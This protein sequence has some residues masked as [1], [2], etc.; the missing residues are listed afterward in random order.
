[1][2]RRDHAAVLPKRAVD[3]GVGCVAGAAR[4]QR[5]GKLRSARRAAAPHRHV[6]NE[7][8]RRAPRQQC[9]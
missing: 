9:P 1:M 8:G 5:A 3:C 2:S 4:V 6:R 7:R